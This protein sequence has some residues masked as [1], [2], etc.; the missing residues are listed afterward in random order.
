MVVVVVVVVVGG[1][2]DENRFVYHS[3]TRN[4]QETFSPD[5]DDFLRNFET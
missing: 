2:G 1:G 4:C 3:V 5:R